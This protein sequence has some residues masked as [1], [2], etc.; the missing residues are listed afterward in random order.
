MGRDLC[1]R[2]VSLA[3][4]LRRTDE[5]PGLLQ[6]RALLGGSFRGLEGGG[7]VQN[8]AFGTAGVGER[9]D[10]GSVNSAWHHLV[11]GRA[12][13]LLSTIE[14]RWVFFTLY[15]EGSRGG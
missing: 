10:A 14:N 3:R 12:R 15:F 5:T 9:G 1:C 8:L 6:T 11:A 2:G 7:G 13:F 4:F